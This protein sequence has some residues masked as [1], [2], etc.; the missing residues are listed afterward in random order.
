[1]VG[2]SRSLLLVLFFNAFIGF[3]L[4]LFQQNVLYVGHAF[5]DNYLNNILISLNEEFY[6]ES[7]LVQHFN[8]ENKWL[9]VAHICYDKF[10]HP[11]T[12]NF[13]KPIKVKQIPVLIKASSSNRTQ[14]LPDTLSICP[15]LQMDAAEKPWTNK[16]E[17]LQLQ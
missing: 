6:G 13:E 14:G 9:M 5:D 12:C 2:L 15:T 3:Q 4:L 8:G 16:G 10:S 11:M 1:M 7:K 17:F